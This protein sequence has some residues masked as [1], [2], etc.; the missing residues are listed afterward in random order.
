MA[1]S[2]SLSSQPVSG[3]PVEPTASLFTL[4]TPPPPAPDS[5]SVPDQAVV[6]PQPIN[7]VQPPVPT[8]FFGAAAPS[9]VSDPGPTPVSDS[10]SPLP[11][12]APAEPARP[13]AAT[14]LADD[15]A[16]SSVDPAAPPAP[17]TDKSPLEILEEILAG[18][19]AEK[20]LKDQ[21]EAEEKAQKEQEAAEFAAKEA[22]FAAEAKV[23]LEANAQALE[24]AKM[25]REKV[26]AEL[27][28]NAPVDTAVVNTIGQLTH[29]TITEA[30]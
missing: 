9:P 28:Q 15:A 11:A 4:P 12:P 3:V 13:F 26:E 18:A 6:A 20:N 5:N 23:K 2:L 17:G 8:D 30:A 21:K 29:D 24:E 19:D 25:Q 16:A 1:D 7:S 14:P 10:F 22:A 27:A